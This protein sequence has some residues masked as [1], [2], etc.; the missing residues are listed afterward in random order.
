MFSAAF[1]ALVFSIHPMRTEVVS[2]VTDRKESL[3]A[4]FFL[5][6][7]WF[8]LKGRIKPAVVFY[9]LSLMSKAAT[10]M[11]PVAL[12]ILDR[13]PLRKPSFAL[14]EK[15]PFAV[16]AIMFGLIALAARNEAS[17]LDSVEVYSVK[18][19]ILQAAYTPAFYFW[20]TFALYEG[21]PSFDS[22]SPVA[23]AI[24]GLTI[25]LSVLF[26]SLR[27]QYPAVMACWLFSIVMLM[28][29]LGVI[30]AGQQVVADRYS[31][32]SCLGWPVL[33]GGL[34]RRSLQTTARRSE[35]AGRLC[36]ISQ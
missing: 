34:L 3:A 12:L 2:M 20:K 16:L 22:F 4:F 33:L 13:Y 17:E 8:Y 30:Q 11:L 18:A 19:R 10:I 9:F 14:K 28:P 32:L 15:V 23:V 6:T 35:N 27:K 5:W 21:M 24:V 7:I 25:V 31:Y 26:Y 29:V 36:T 1:A